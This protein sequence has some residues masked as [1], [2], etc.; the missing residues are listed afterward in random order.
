MT[1]GENGT[2]VVT[3]A[4]RYKIMQNHKDRGCQITAPGTNF[5][6]SLWVQFDW[7]I[8][9]LIPLYIFIVAF[10]LQGRVE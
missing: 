8:A 6:S 3:G 5:A 1:E 9:M 7:N 10:M 4:H 2:Y